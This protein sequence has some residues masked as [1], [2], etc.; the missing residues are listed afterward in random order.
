MVLVKVK[1]LKSVTPGLKSQSP[2]TSCVILGKSLHLSELSPCSMK[3]EN[4]TSELSVRIVAE[5]LAQCQAQGRQST[6]VLLPPLP[7]LSLS[8]GSDQPPQG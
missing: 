7:Q 2:L 4:P 5:M 8:L 1:S 3:E 6:A